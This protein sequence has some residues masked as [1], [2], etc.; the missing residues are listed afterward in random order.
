VKRLGPRADLFF[1]YRAP[2]IEVL[3]RIGPAAESEAS[4]LEEEVRTNSD[5][6]IRHLAARAL[7]RIRAK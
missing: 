3:G 1:Q 2:V 7:R 5:E 4:S 6:R